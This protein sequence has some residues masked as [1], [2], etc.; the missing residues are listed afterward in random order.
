M[1]PLRTRVDLG[2]IA[3]KGYSAFRKATALMVPQYQSVYSY[4]GCSLRGFLLVRRDALGVFCSPSRLGNWNFGYFALLKSIFIW[5]KGKWIFQCVYDPCLCFPRIISG[6]VDSGC[7]I[8]WLLLCGELRFLSKCPVYGTK[9][10]NDEASV[11]PE[12]F[13]A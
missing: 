3:M 11:M 10:S 13:N 7:R 5:I 4:Q 8:H 2:T 12:L 9:Q 6:H 1:L